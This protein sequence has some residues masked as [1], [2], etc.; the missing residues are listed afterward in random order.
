MKREDKMALP[1][2]CEFLRYEIP[3]KKP[4]IFSLMRYAY[5]CDLS[6]FDCLQRTLFV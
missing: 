3:G 5:T 1:R 4:G 2:L 6:L